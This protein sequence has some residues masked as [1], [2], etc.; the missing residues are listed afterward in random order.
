[1]PPLLQSLKTSKKLE[2]FPLMLLLIARNLRRLVRA[3]ISY[4][5]PLPTKE[6]IG[7]HRNINH[8]IGGL[9]KELLAVS[10]GFVNE[11]HVEAHL[12][13]PVYPFFKLQP[14]SL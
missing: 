8:F 2:H 1:M 12:I 5:Y 7:K 14:L 4:Y 11:N 13:S 6:E 9:L 3:K 10:A